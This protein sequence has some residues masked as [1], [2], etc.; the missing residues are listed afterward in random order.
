VMIPAL[1]VVGDQFQNGEVFLPELMLAGDAAQRVSQ[2][3]EAAIASQGKVTEP[4]GTVVIGTV[5]GDIHD[6]G[7]NIVVTMLKAHG[8]RVVDLGRNVA[9]S[10]FLTAAQENR[11]QVV[12]MSSLMTTTRPMI[13]NTINLFSEVG[14]RDNF[15]MI[16]G[17]GCV[18]EEWASTLGAV[19][20]CKKFS[21]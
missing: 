8:F 21:A 2:H 7:K 16:V 12:A 1:T 9:P 10:G 5:M 13:E 4:K 11:A 6:I 15:K 14:V 3:V 18:T 17:G 20:L 19:E